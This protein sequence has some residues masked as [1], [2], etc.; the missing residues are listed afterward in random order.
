MAS[1]NLPYSF[2][3]NTTADANQVNSNFAAVKSF[4]ESSV[5]QA[6]GTVSVAN[7]SITLAK[8]AAAVAQAL[9]PTATVVPFAGTTLP[10]GWLWCD[11]V[12]IPVQYTTLIAAV[13]ANTPNLKG[14]TIYGRDTA[15]ALFATMFQTG[16]SVNGVASHAHSVSLTTGPVGN[17]SH[18]GATTNA[19]GHYH[20][21]EVAGVLG[22]NP[23]D[24]T[25]VFAG[26]TGNVFVTS[27]VG[28]HAHGINADGN[29]DHSVNGSTV[30]YGS[31]GGNLSPYVVLNYIIKV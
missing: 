14:K 13:G 19:G 26:G 27:S 16:G 24:Q 4:V 30:S 15:D 23:V 18:G 1:L 20:T 5:V 22:G 21:Y 11:G 28:D 3:N 17:H 8:L 10:D 6:D 31:V 12:A 2:T 29:H 9:V 25:Y 7:S